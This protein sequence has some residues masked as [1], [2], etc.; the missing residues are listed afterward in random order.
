[1]KAV[2]N[3]SII[4]SIVMLTL[5]SCLKDQCDET[6]TFV[7]YN[8]IYVNYEDIR[9]DI[10]TDAPRNLEIPGKLYV[11]ENYLFINEQNKGV[12]IYDNSNPASPSNIGYIAI[13]G[14]VD[15]AIKDG[16]MYA[17]N[18]MD[19]LTI[20]IE[21]PKEA[22]MV[23][24]DEDVYNNFRFHEGRGVLVGYSETE[25]TLE[26]NCGDLNFNN[27]RFFQDDVLLSNSE[28]DASGGNRST[29]GVAGSLARFTI[30]KDHLYVIDNSQL[31]IFDIKDA[32][33]PRRVSDFYVEWGIETLFPY[34]DNLFIG[35]NNGM[36]IYSLR[37]P[38]A[39]TYLSAFRHATACDPV[40]VNGDVAYVTLRSGRTCE[41]FDNQLDVID[42]SDLKI[43]KLLKSF[44]MDNPH[45]LSVR[46]DRLYLCEGDLGLKIFDES[47]PTKVGDK[48]KTHL[49][50]IQ[51]VDVIALGDALLLVIGSEGLHQFDISDKDNPV[52][53]SVIRPVNIK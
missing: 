21:N 5:S 33:K 8:P 37:N 30:A 9:V 32:A 46:N 12:H 51:A 40:F 36:H 39:P 14:N 28:F 11:Y 3:F 4:I 18:Y 2:F 27:N 13:P 19:L 7:Q 10:F 47:E 35:A 49:K 31:F 1:M 29:T 16:Y 44:E 17:D 20:N 34:G 15:I 23:C 41:S 45:G 50:N 22:Q 53:L 52:E 24:R 25:I 43:P 48:L 38:S 26:I 6:R 42:V